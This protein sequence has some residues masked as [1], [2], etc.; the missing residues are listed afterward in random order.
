VGAAVGNVPGAI[1]GFILG[2]LIETAVGF[3]LDR[4][5][6]Q[7]SSEDQA[8]ADAATRA[9]ALIQTQEKAL[10]AHEDKGRAEAKKQADALRTRVD[11]AAAPEQVYEIQRD[12]FESGKEADKQPSR[13]DRGLAT[14]MLKEWVLEHAGDEEDANKETSEAQWEAGRTRIFG[15]GDSLD[16]HPEIFAYQSRAHWSGLGFDGVT[17]A[18]DMIK[19]AGAAGATVK[20]V[21]SDWDGKQVEFKST[22]RPDALIAMIERAHKPMTEEGKK[23]IRENRFRLQAKL[24]LDDAD[25]AVYVDEWE[26]ELTFVGPD[27]LWWE[28]QR[29]YSR[30]ARIREAFEEDDRTVD[31][32]ISPD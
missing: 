18:A 11:A 5:T 15:K 8:A 25:D 20:Q 10:D 7:A 14:R 13:D 21:M 19:Q 29:R 2:V 4:I 1:V 27:A 12:A 30:G 17:A 24:S 16:G 28:R 31:F 9:G 32:V 3:I 6:G 26:Y 22:T 23:A